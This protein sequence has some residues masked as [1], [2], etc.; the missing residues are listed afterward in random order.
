M[1]II[2][3]IKAHLRIAMFFVVA[4]SG[5]AGAHAADFKYNKS[6]NSIQMEGR[7][8][9]GDGLIFRSLLRSHPQIETVELSRSVGGEYTSSLEISMEIKKRGLNTVSSNYCR[10]GCAYIWL[11]G[12]TRK[13]IGPTNPEIH[14]PYADAT[15]E[16]LPKLTHAWLDALGL[17]SAFAHAV[18][19]SVG[20]NNNFV[21]LTPE[22]LTKFG[23]FRKQDA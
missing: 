21:K 1:T 5:V 13:V 19:R 20:P 15:R 22:F 9:A 12:A 8:F 18:V 14:L 4:M 17:S 10:S 3:L 23:A 2:L 7:I 16:A 11:A 6:E